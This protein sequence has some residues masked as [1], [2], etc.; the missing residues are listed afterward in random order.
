MRPRITRTR[1]RKDRAMGKCLH[2]V[3]TKHGGAT[4][5]EKQFNLFH[6]LL[7]HQ[8][9]WH[10]LAIFNQSRILASKSVQNNKNV[11]EKRRRNQN[12]E[13]DDS[14]ESVGA[15]TGQ[16]AELDLNN[17]DQSHHEEATPTDGTDAGDEHAEAEGGFVNL[18]E[19]LD[20]EVEIG[21]AR[22]ADGLLE[23]EGDEAGEEEGAEGV[24][25]EGDE[26]LG[27]GR[28]GGAGGIGNETVGGVVGIPGETEEDG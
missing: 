8:W 18:G 25:V 19:E 6:H 1:T 20:G 11:N 22:E 27:D 24:N 15:A 23:S 2:V 16:R 12:E 5:R 17:I 21:G 10:Y 9:V 7:F 13:R 28:G 14:R 3:S 4:T 26:I